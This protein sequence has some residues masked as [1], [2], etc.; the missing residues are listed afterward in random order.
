MSKAK[1]KLTYTHKKWQ[2]I[3]WGIIKQIYVM[4]EDEISMENLAREFNIASPHLKEIA[5][6]EKWKIQRR[7]YQD[8]ILLKTAEKLTDRQAETRAKGLTIAEA[9]LGYIAELMQKRQLKASVGDLDKIVR[10]MEFLHGNVDSRTETVITAIER[11]I[12]ENQ[13]KRVKEHEDVNAIEA[14]LTGIKLGQPLLEAPE[15]KEDEEAG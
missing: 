1:G 7:V 14:E 13:N 2:R 12:R 4:R 6:T 8:K 10:L 9:A 3:N 5:S 11:A 15:D